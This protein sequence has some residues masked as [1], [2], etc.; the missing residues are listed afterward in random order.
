MIDLSARRAL[1]AIELHLR[2][3]NP[4]LLIAVM[5]W[6]LALMLWAVAIPA[7]QSELVS[8][9][10]GQ[11]RAG[12]VHAEEGLRVLTQ[13]IPPA[14]AHLKMFMDNLGDPRYTEQQLQSLFVI[15]RGLSLDLP[16]GKYRMFC[17]LGASF[18]K[19]QIELPVRGPYTRVRS[20]LEDLLMVIPFASL[21]D[22]SFRRETATDEEIEVRLA[23]TLFTRNVTTTPVA[24]AGG[25]P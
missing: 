2:R 19:F 23:V 14:A 6:L 22:L 5:I 25:K 8:M 11:D 17:E 7:R 13:D 20:F 24:Q 10:N 15:A 1:L 12:R 3:W 21:D 4:W 16:Q 9:S 18:C